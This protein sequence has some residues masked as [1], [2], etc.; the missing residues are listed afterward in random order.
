ML[1]AADWL[2]VADTLSISDSSV[3]KRYRALQV[4]SHPRFNKYSNDYDV[5]LLRTV[6][7]MEL[8]GGVRPVCL[9]RPTELFPPGAA[10][11]ITGWGY[12]QE[13]GFVTDELQQAQVQVIAQPICSQP[14]VYGP[15][16]TPR[17]IC[18]GTMEGGVDSCQGDS[19]GPLVCETDGG[20]WRLAGVVSWGEGC[21][22]RNKPGVYSRVTQLIH[23]V[24]RYDKPEEVEETS[25][26]TTDASPD[27]HT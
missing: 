25:T 24:N 4:L 27:P 23:W 22:R 15:F 21:G 20:E 26:A 17:M 14:A 13:G 6:T 3:G 16:L 7:D 9:P 2:V 10:C 8:T 5:G 11:W 19:G 12:L 18:A 1:E